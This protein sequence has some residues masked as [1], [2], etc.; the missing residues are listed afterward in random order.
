MFKVLSPTFFALVVAWLTTLVLAAVNAATP[1]LASLGMTP[2]LNWGVLA[3]QAIVTIIFVTP[4]WRKVWARVPALRRWYPDL[5]G[6]WDVELESNF[7]RIDATL[8]AA[9]RE[10]PAIDMR[11]APETDLPALGNAIMRARITQSWLSIEMVM[12][13]PS[14]QGPIKE[15]RTLAVDPYRSKDGRHGLNYIFEQENV[16]AVVS[17]DRT[18]LGAARIALDLHDREVLCGR[19]WTDRMWRRGMNTAANLRLTRRP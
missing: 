16:S 1:F 17:D 4:L 7:P 10:A 18:F 5:N 2:G 6:E 19:M 12:W 11:E 15:S 9:K 8:K 3:V 13:N 14:G